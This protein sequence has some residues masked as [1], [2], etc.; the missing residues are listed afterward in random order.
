MVA[1]TDREKSFTARNGWPEDC[2]LS[3]FVQRRRQ[4][5]HPVLTK[6]FL[7]LCP[8]AAMLSGPS[9]ETHPPLPVLLF[10]LV[11]NLSPKDIARSDITSWKLYDASIAYIRLRAENASTTVRCPHAVIY[12]HPIGMKVISMTCIYAYV[13]LATMWKGYTCTAQDFISVLKTFGS[14]S[15]LSVSYL[16]GETPIQHPT[17]VATRTCR[18]CITGKHKCFLIDFSR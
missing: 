2:F 6:C 17:V 7:Q 13:F 18:H 16:S 15:S 11:Q 3:P 12:P 8:E 5:A 9:V 10:L 4:M 1:P 14:S